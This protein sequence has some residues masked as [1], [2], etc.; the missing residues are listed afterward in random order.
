MLTDSS[1]SAFSDQ[2]Q[3]L[4]FAAT[5]DAP[6]ALRLTTHVDESS[7]PSQFTTWGK[8]DGAIV[9]GKS[10]DV[11]G[12]LDFGRNAET[13]GGTFG[14]ITYK[15][16]FKSDATILDDIKAYAQGFNE[17]DNSNVRATLIVAPSVNN[18]CLPY[19]ESTTP[20][21][22]EGPTCTD[23]LGGSNAT[24]D[25]VTAAIREAGSQ[26][27]QTTILPRPAL[28]QLD[29]LGW[30]GMDI[31][32]DYNPTYNPTI[33]W[34]KGFEVGSNGNA[35]ADFGTPYT[36]GTWGLPQ[37][38]NAS[39]GV[40]E[41]SRCSPFP[42]A[43]VYPPNAVAY[44]GEWID[45]GDWANSQSPKKTYFIGGVMVGLPLSLRDGWHK[46]EDALEM[47]KWS[48]VSPPYLDRWHFD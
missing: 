33:T 46:M 17:G 7:P 24:R 30:A 21:C 42:F 39:Y 20:C 10:G 41:D 18:D 40:C 4:V 12:F 34:E 14:V 38:W 29:Y 43:E 32:A 3:C 16:L 23:P 9:K 36:T 25:E 2:G 1:G 47:T 35:L 6:P 27:G 19:G 11:I 44:V 13:S 28:N 8:N 45:I 15:L 48:L 37:L 5:S 22:S 31:E 26:F